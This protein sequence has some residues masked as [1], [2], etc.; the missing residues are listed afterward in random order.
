LNPVLE[1]ILRSNDVTSITLEEGEL[2]QRIIDSIEPKTSLEVGLAYGTSSLFICEA[3]RRKG[4]TK[5]TVIDPYQST[6][7]DNR[8][9]KNIRRAGY[10]DMISFIEKPSEIALPEL[11]KEN[12]RIDFAFIDGF[13]T[14]DHTLLDFFYINRMLNVG[15]VVAFD[16]T[17][18]PSISKVCRFVSRF[19]A[20]RLLEVLPQKRLARR[21]PYVIKTISNSLLNHIVSTSSKRYERIRND[22]KIALSGRCIA[23]L[24]EKEDIRRESWHAEF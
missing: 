6:R 14:F 22:L 1:E 13:H 10:E 12:H 5:H 9:L 8:G 15:G 18:W 7:F 24:K 19:S 3:L 20:Y 2:L 4:A 11:L 23:F 21:I 17:N 16:D